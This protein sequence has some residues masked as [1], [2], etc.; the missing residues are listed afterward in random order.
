[1][2][3]TTQQWQTLWI[4]VNLATMNDGS[5][6]YGAIENG[7]LAIANGKIAWLGTMSDLS[8]SEYKAEHVI[9]GKG[10]WLTPG[11]VDCHTHLVFGGNRMLERMEKS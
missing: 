3:M 1:M 9:D 6:R 7:A 10:A 4:N 5:N 2:S 8:A 11:L